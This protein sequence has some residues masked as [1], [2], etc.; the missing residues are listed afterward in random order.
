MCVRQT[1][2]TLGR[3]A[4]AGTWA[5]ARSY[6]AAPRALPACGQPLP[7]THPH[8]FP[9]DFLR[10][11]DTDAGGSIAYDHLTPG[12]PAAEYEERRRALMERLPVGSVVVLMGARTKYMS[13]NIFYSFRQ[14]SNFWYL[15]G[16]QE[17]DAALLLEKNSSARGY[18]MTMFVAPREPHKELWDGPT[19]G[20][21]GATAV[22]GADDAVA[23]DPTLMLQALKSAVGRSEHLYVDLPR[24]VSVPRQSMRRPRFS[25]HD[26][27]CPPS[28]TGYDLFSRK[29]DFDS[30]ARLLSDRRNTHSLEREMDV[31]RSRKSANEVRVMRHAGR[32]SGAAM[33]EMMRA[34]HPGMLE[35][36]AQ[37]EFEYGC[38][39]RGAE[40]QAYVPVFA[41][42][43]NALMIHYVRNDALM[44]PG[45]VM[46]VDAGCEYAGYAS[47]I[48]R[49]FP[50]ARDGRFSGPQRDLYEALLRTLKGCTALATARQGYSLAELHRRSVEM[51]ST[52]LRALGFSLRAGMVERVLYPHY[53]GHWLGI[54]LH[55][56]SS[57]ERT[58]RLKDGMVLTIEP[59]IYVPDDPAYPAAFRGL[60]MRVEDDIAV[61]ESDNLVLSADAPKEVVDI[62]A[63]CGGRI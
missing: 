50:V 7:H 59:G 38:A 5:R 21:E 16:M 54:D 18:K 63:V 43:R 1:T 55:D 29:S 2:R 46:S 53:I 36:A 44:Q 47:D 52:E 35:R 30:V 15:T 49:S 14:D 57:V 27:L 17:P 23:N 31:L 9:Q 26:F 39:R 37:A 41:S 12:I 8:L 33:A 22:F 28:A 60:G 6:A 4:R 13:K 61:G 3:G 62:E 40:R 11:T 56:T 48:T 42:G 25:L 34:V 32:I 51:L 58:T 24:Q 19:C 20:L 45:V 10:G